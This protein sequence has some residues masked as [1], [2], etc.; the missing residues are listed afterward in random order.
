MFII[1][2]QTNTLAEALFFL[3]RK[4]TPAHYITERAAYD[5]HPQPHSISQYLTFTPVPFSFLLPD[6]RPGGI[7]SGKLTTACTR[8]CTPDR[9]TPL[10]REPQQ[11]SISTY[12][13]PPH[14][15]NQ[16]CPPRLLPPRALQ[17]ETR[18]TALP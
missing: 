3:Q 10:S 16:P 15:V 18:L 5:Q 14:A 6:P 2:T 7:R 1:L 17:T 8:L 9:T 4:P 13:N 12:P 11:P